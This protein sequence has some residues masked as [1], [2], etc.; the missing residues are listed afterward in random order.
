MT[1]LSLIEGTEK[2]KEGVNINNSSLAEIDGYKVNE[3]TFNTIK[4]KPNIIVGGKKLG[5]YLIPFIY[6][7]YYNSM[8]LIKLIYLVKLKVEI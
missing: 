4:S 2:F 7:S 1:G 3:N 5:K 8:K 6:L